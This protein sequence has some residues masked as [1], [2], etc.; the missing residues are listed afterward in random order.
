M[1]VS[2]RI[3]SSSTSDSLAYLATKAAGKA[4]EESTEAGSTA[5]L[6]GGSYD[7]SAHVGLSVDALLVLNVAREETAY[8]Q[9]ALTEAERENLD[10]DALEKRE[11]A[12]FGHF[13]DEG[14]RKAYYRAYIEYFDS[15]P[16]E[17]Q[18]SARYA[19]TREPAVTA[20]HAI[21]YNESALDMTAPDA[22]LENA[23]AGEGKGSRRA[24]PISAIFQPSQVDF[25]NAARVVTS[26]IS[27][28]DTMYATGF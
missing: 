20:L 10:T 8:S 14:D 6:A 24:T 2:N 18:R 9:P 19:G 15:M 23:T 4:V 21:A 26:R 3:A 7:P 25:E 28:A 11:Y 16:A 22:A 1:H 17:D 12:A 13:L 27:R 5:N